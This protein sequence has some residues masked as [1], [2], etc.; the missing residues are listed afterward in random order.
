MDEER[1]MVIHFMDSTKLKL[2]FPK[3]VRSDETVPV[4]LDHALDKPAL[5]VEVDG[6]LMAIP[7][8]N[9][10]YVRIYPAANVLPDYVIKGA[11][12]ED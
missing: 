12:I 2:S 3:Q 1:S 5:M 9:V 10:K 7:F 4:R 8:A 11:H 6:S